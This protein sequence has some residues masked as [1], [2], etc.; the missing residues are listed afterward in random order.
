VESGRQNGIDDA[1]EGLVVF[2]DRELVCWFFRSNIE[3]SGTGGAATTKLYLVFSA[4]FQ[5]TPVFDAGHSHM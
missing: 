2:E 1:P 5:M 3:R 4:T